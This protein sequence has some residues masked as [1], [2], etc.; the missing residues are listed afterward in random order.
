MQGVAI[1]LVVVI[2]IAGAAF[3][4][5]TATR[6][7][8]LEA[9][10][11]P[12]PPS[13]R[14]GDTDDVL[15]SERLNRVSR[16]GVV[17]SVAF[18][19]FITFYWLAERGRMLTKED[20][21]HELSVRRG[22]QY[23]DEGSKFIEGAE[24]IGVEC[25]R[26]HGEGGV[27]GE[28]EYLDPATGQKRL[29]QVP[30]LQTVFARYEKPPGVGTTEDF[31]RETIQRG[32]PGTDM[33][34]WGDQYGGPLTAQQID[35]IVN[36]LESI[37]KP[38]TVAPEATG[39]QLFAQFCSV[40]HGVNGT[41]GSGPAMVGGSEAVQF[42][43]IEDHIAF[44]KSGSTRGVSYGTSGQGTGAMPKWE[45]VLTEEQIRAVVEYERSL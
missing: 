5:R 34:T 22:A 25:S 39:Q 26:C 6:R 30:E 2:F 17:F 29:V 31:I 1:A 44:V 37:Q 20:S 23:F 8:S 3:L 12:V 27:G 19:G 18:A 21:L 15:E 4:L 33:P 41:G 24:V 40:C 14:P 11:P 13:R 42:P 36:Y 45:G 7:P 32:R 38:I 9:K 35:D 16:W 10:A 28:N 43:S